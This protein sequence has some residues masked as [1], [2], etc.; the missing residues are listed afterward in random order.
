[1]TDTVNVS[2]PKAVTILKCLREILLSSLY[3]PQ[4]MPNRLERLTMQAVFA[5]QISD[6]VRVLD[7]HLTDSSENRSKNTDRAMAAQ[8]LLGTPWEVLLSDNESLLILQT[9]TR[10]DLQ[11]VKVSFPDQPKNA[12][13]FHRWKNI[14]V[15]ASQP[16]EFGPPDENGNEI[17][18]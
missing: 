14:D 10:E 1:M 18:T 15:E 6:Y 2:V 12:K 5:D 8:M 13:A 7:L 9:P 4:H 11:S 17:R 3:L 16:T